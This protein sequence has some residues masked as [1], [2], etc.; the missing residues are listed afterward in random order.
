MS[1]TLVSS[2]LAPAVVAALVTVI[3]G[4]AFKFWADAQIARQKAAFDKDIT[5]LTSELVAERAAR[6]EQQR[7][8]SDRMRTEYSWLYTKRAE[9]MNEIYTRLDDVRTAFSQFYRAFGSPPG[10][11]TTL[12]QMNKVRVAVYAFQAAYLP[13]RILFP[14][15][16][17]RKL[18]ELNRAY[19]SIANRYQLRFKLDDEEYV[20]YKET[21]KQP[22]VNTSELITE[23]E[24]EFRRLYGL[25]DETEDI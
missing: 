21:I 16:L 18:G 4:T 13:K 24:K 22:D 8:L 12:D 20:A 7:R 6:E 23:L 25:N 10:E 15:A 1:D 14:S 11:P 17:A 3:L 9:A 19:M 5:R 2:L